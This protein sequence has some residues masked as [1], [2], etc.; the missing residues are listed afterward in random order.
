[1]GGGAAVAET[2]WDEGCSG[3]VLTL[4]QNGRRR[5]RFSIRFVSVWARCGLAFERQGIS[6]G[7]FRTNRP[8]VRL[9]FGTCGLYPHSD[10]TAKLNSR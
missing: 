6:P 3:K 1:M 8:P 7:T 5:A 4:Y 10:P 2:G 9:R